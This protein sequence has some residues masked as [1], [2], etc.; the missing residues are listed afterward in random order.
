MP[1]NNEVALFL[2]LMDEQL[3]TSRRLSGKMLS[4][5]DS[6]RED[7]RLDGFKIALRCMEIAIDTYKPTETLAEEYHEAQ[8]RG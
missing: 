8:G 5:E 7:G 6:A 3:E 2:K 4:R 1:T